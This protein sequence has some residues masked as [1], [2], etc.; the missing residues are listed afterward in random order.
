M[1]S[2]KCTGDRKILPTLILAEIQKLHPNR[3][4]NGNGYLGDGHIYRGSNKNLLDSNTKNNMG[5]M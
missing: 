3:V 2:K 4:H 5:R 1:N